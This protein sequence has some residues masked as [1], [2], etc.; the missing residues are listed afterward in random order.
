MVPRWSAS[1]NSRKLHLT[2]FE[3]RIR[4]VK[5]LVADLP[6]EALVS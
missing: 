3:P 4:A 6:A 1:G 2:G 5:V